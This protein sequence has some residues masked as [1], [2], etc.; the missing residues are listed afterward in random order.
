[1]SAGH[2]ENLSRV[3]LCCC[4]NLLLFLL[5]LLFQKEVD[6]PSEWW[7]PTSQCVQV[8]ESLRIT[9]CLGC[10]TAEIN[11]CPVTPDHTPPGTVAEEPG[12]AGSSRVLRGAFGVGSSY[13]LRF[14]HGPFHAEE[15]TYMC[16]YAHPMS[17][18]SACSLFPHHAQHPPGNC[19]CRCTSGT[20]P[21]EL[22]LATGRRTETPSW[23]FS[24]KLPFNHWLH[25]I[26]RVICKI[27]SKDELGARIHSPS[28][29]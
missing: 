27:P 17:Q 6:D 12:E 28:A 3:A 4:L 16:L 19:V 22:T 21:N 1:M 26:P 25:L 14:R 7:W 2:V 20:A 9:F 18:P 23:N 24:E 29:W 15:Y 10:N 5:F 8:L 11:C 13:H